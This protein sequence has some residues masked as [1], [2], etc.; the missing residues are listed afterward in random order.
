AL[1]GGYAATAALAS[2][3][4]RLLPGDRAEATVWAMTASPLLYVTIALW[5]FHAPRLPRVL[6]AV[7]GAALI[8]GAVVS[9][10][11]VRP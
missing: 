3:A 9:L 10:L 11:G 2:L 7:W 6:L 8:G 5:C 1:L 4:A